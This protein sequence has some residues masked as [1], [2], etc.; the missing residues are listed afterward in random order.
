MMNPN[1]SGMRYPSS[2]GMEQPMAQMQHQAPLVQAPATPSVQSAPSSGNAPTPTSGSGSSNTNDEGQ[3][4][5]SL[6]LHSER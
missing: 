4:S 1:Y 5:D 6:S 3:G 2:Y